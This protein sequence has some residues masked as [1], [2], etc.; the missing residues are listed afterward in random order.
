[1]IA[2]IQCK[3]C[4]HFYNY[5][6]QI[7]DER[8]LPDFVAIPRCRLGNEIKPEGHPADPNCFESRIAQ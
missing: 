1:M 7:K 3:D 6:K 5:F 8:G 2:D 4:K